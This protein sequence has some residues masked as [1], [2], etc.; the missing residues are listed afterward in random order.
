MP[1][2][3]NIKCIAKGDWR[4]GLDSADSTEEIFVTEDS[5]VW[6]CCFY[7]A[8]WIDPNKTIQERNIDVKLDDDEYIA[9]LFKDDPD[10]NNCSTKPIDNIIDHDFFMKHISKENWESDNPP[11]MC[12]VCCHNLPGEERHK[13]V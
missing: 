9:K 6:P 5:R 12:V 13:M 11:P 2:K 3:Y 10:W 7:T 4:D 1:S 8:A